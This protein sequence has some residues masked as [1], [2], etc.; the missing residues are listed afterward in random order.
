M[1][2]TRKV[3]TQHG[4]SA[5]RVF[6]WLALIIGLS[7]SAFWTIFPL[8]IDDTLKSETLVGIFFTLIALIGFVVAILSPIVLRWVSKIY[9]TQLG[10]LMCIG[11]LFLFTFA[12]KVLHFYFIE[13]VRSVFSML[14]G[15]AIA[16]YVRDFATERTLGAA[17]GRFYLFAN[18][19]WFIG[20]LI[21]GFLGDN[22]S[23]D[24]VFLF[25]AVMYL[26][27]FVVFQ[28]NYRTQT[29]F[30]EHVKEKEKFTKIVGRNI[31]D[32]FRAPEMWKVFVV[33]TGLSFWWVIH[34]IY[35]PIYIS[36]QLGFS[37]TVVG[38]VLAGGI[39]PLLLLEVYIGKLADKHGMR[40]F[41][42]IGFLSLAGFTFLFNVIPVVSVVLVLMAVVNVGS[43]FIEPLQETYLFKAAKAKDEDRF[44]GIFKM[45]YPLANVVGPLIAAGLIFIGG[46]TALWYGVVA[47]LLV[48]TAVSFRAKL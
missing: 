31:F 37:D 25:S 5:G 6:A 4:R 41:L 32:F 19:G 39:I 12:N 9:L 17:E 48:F 34:E 42:T 18:I 14:V 44:Y 40:P 35:F 13:S 15:L 45:S 43:A 47:L 28:Y 36:T 16:L 22:V 29:A 23:R 27:T 33:G 30:L 8:V 7:N 46:F 38:L 26:I 20:P 11:A 2:F 10:L 21:G 3:S 24:S 1:S